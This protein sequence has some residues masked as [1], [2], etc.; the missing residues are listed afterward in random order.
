[1]KKIFQLN[2][3]PNLTQLSEAKYLLQL[4]DPSELDRLLLISRFDLAGSAFTVHKWQPPEDAGDAELTQNHGTWLT[5]KGIPSHRKNTQT[6]MS[7]CKG[8]G[9]FIKAEEAFNPVAGRITKVL[10]GN[11]D[12][13]NILHFIPL[14]EGSICYTIQV[15][16]IGAPTLGKV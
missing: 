1:M 12:L 15:E 8:F 7:L 4:A 6:F 16:S 10:I 14:Q 13:F 2:T 5:L 11:C 3:T 9:L